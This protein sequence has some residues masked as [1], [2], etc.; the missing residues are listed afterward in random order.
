MD[1]YSYATYLR[2]T[3]SFPSDTIANC[4]RCALSV[5]RSHAEVGRLHAYS[6]LLLSASKQHSFVRRMLC[7]TYEMWNIMNHLKQME[8]CSKVVWWGVGTNCPSFPE[9][10]CIRD[11]NTPCWVVILRQ[12]VLTVLRTSSYT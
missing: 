3:G 8:S 11:I 6:K 2:C 4:V 5:L 7:N 1:T 9:C 10:R 12:F